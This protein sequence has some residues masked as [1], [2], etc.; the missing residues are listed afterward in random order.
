MLKNMDG[1]FPGGEFDG[2]E[3]SGWEFSWYRHRLTILVYRFFFVSMLINGI[4]ICCYCILVYNGVYS[5]LICDF[6]KQLNQ[7]WFIRIMYYRIKPPPKDTQDFIRFPAPPPLS[8]TSPGDTGTQFSVIDFFKF[9]P[10]QYDSNHHKP[11]LLIITSKISYCLLQFQ[12]TC[13]YE[14]HTPSHPT[15]KA[16]SLF[17]TARGRSK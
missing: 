3:F 6:V 17:L 16:N 14:F 5:P 1:N 15:S 9:N 11:N 4:K 8:E 7:L 12:I 2:W 13:D 10:T